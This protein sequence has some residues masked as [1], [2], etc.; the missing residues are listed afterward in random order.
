MNW[1]WV[2]SGIG[3]FVCA[4]F[5]VVMTTA[6]SYTFTDRVFCSALLVS[7]GYLFLSQNPPTEAAES[8]WWW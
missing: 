2:A 3:L 8:P 1:R 7:F 4:I 6:Q 5:A